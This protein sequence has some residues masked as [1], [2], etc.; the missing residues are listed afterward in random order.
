MT[1]LHL[2]ISGFADEGE[3][4]RYAAIEQMPQ[5]FNGNPLTVEVESVAPSTD[6][7]PAPAGFVWVLN[8]T[9]FWNLEGPNFMEVCGSITACEAVLANG[10]TNHFTNRYDLDSLERVVRTPAHVGWQLKTNLKTS[11]PQNDLFTATLRKVR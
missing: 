3:A 11:S 1:T 10:Y 2:R 7:M 9:Y 8:D 4:A 5:T 6:F